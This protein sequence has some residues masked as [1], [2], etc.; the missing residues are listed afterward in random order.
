MY[1]EANIETKIQK[2]AVDKIN[3]ALYISKNIM[4]IMIYINFQI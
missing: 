3:N 1:L 2:Y 4:Y